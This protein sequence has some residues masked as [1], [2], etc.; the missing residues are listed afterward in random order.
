M[1]VNMPWTETLIMDERVSFIMDYQAAQWNVSELCLEYGISRTTAYKY[2]ARYEETGVQGR[3]D[4]SRAP[5][6]IANKTA[7]AIE[8]EIIA[9]GRKHP[10][11]GPENS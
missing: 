5:H 2:I 6:T 9:L 4:L 7:V 3:F 10:R 11:Y 8:K 1:E